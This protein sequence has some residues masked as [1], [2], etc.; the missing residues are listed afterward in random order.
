MNIPGMSEQFPSLKFGINHV[1]LWKFWWK[2]IESSKVNDGAQVDDR[3]ER[4][5]FQ[6]KVGRQAVHRASLDKD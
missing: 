4:N 3:A 1:V 6:R 5:I 2:F